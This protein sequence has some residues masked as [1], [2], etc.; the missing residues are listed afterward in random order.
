M[1]RFKG[2]KG[3]I[4]LVILA[5]MVVGYYYY[6]S[7][8]KQTSRE[9]VKYEVMTPVQKVLSR[10][11]ETNYPSTPREVVKYFSDITQ[12]FYNEEYTDDE[13]YQMAMRM[14]DIYDEK[15]IANQ[16]E[17]DYMT[18]LKSDIDEF[19]ENQRTISSY[20]LTSTL[21]VETFEADGDEWARL[22]C[23][24]SI[25]EGV[26]VNSDTVFLLR[27]D[28]TT[29]HYK[30]YGWDLAATGSDPAIVSPDS[31]PALDENVQ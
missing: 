5:V 3:M 10:N 30:I 23:L 25:K 31:Q 24:Y 26:L 21:D 6:L 28:K 2:T 1:K 16:T 7:N 15:L 14:R 9:E 11:M 17:S 18:K 27:R 29:G 19:K 12:C 4:I 22:H 8:R 20:S 13:L